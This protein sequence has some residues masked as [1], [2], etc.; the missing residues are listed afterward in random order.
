MADTFDLFRRLSAGA[1]F[2]RKTFHNDPE[3]VKV[4]ISRIRMYVIKSG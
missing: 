1:K 2:N 4:S 3:N